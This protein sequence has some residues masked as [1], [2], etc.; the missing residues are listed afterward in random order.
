MKSIAQII[1]LIILSLLIF[2]CA[3]QREMANNSSGRLALK[4]TSQVKDSLEYDLIIFDQ[5][6]DYWL[7]SRSFQKN[8]YSNSYLQSMNNLYVIEWNRRYSMGDHKIESYI[9]YSP[10]NEYDFELN[11]KLYMYFKYFEESN[12][13]KLLPYKSR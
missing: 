1:G 8:Q 7:S 10:F 2:S 5:G 9:D 6:F 3:S 4:D 12:R 13:I 11:Y